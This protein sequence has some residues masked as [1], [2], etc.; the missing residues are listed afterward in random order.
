ML[1][2]TVQSVTATRRLILT[3]T[4][5]TEANGRTYRLNPPRTKQLILGW[6]VHPHIRDNPAARVDLNDIVAGAR[7][8]VLA[9]DLGP[10]KDAPARDVS[11]WTNQ[12]GHRYLYVKPIG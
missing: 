11:V 6:T 10:G 8:R 5:V 2:G 12:S 7:A 9:T 3:V 1:D 4:S